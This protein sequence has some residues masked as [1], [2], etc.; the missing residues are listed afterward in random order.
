VLLSSAQYADAVRSIRRII[1]NGDNMRE[2]RNEETR[3]TRYEFDSWLSQVEHAEKHA[4]PSFQS[5]EM[6]AS[7]FFGDVDW[8]ESLKMAQYGWPEG[9][10]KA[11]AISQAILNKI[12]SLIE[13]EHVQYEVAG[14]DF[15]VAMVNQGVPECWIRTETTLESG[16]GF[17]HVRIVFNLGARYDVSAETMVTKGAAGAALVQALEMGG[18]RCEVVLATKAETS[19]F[20]S[21]E[22]VETFATIKQAD[23][24]LDIDRLIFA[25]AHPAS[26][27][28]IIFAIR[29]SSPKFNEVGSSVTLQ[30]ADRGDIYIERA[31]GWE[32]EWSSPEAAIQ[33][34]IEQLKKQGVIL[35]EAA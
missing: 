5:Y 12:T 32:A 8:H 34:I 26:H 24:P 16:Q 20:S 27:R 35:A 25:L 23:Q 21:K 14:N 2:S 3:T 19:G 4:R 18:I 29:E 17:K 15:D 6:A 13:R 28:R 30:A 11:D 33:W 1:P 9:V 7:A 31:A 10:K 22:H